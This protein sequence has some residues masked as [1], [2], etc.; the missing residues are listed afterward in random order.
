M[1]TNNTTVTLKCTFSN[2]VHKL[3]ETNYNLPRAERWKFNG[4]NKLTDAQKLELFDKIVQ[5]HSECSASLG[6]FQYEKREKKRI[7]NARVARGY[8]FKK[9]TK[10][11]DYLKSL[12]TAK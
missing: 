12:E 5:L 7:H 11:E 9:K 6:S 10:K 8:K 3:L 1:K 4:K 2:E